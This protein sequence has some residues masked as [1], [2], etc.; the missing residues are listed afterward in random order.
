MFRR[1][2]SDGLERVQVE[3]F[4]NSSQQNKPQKASAVAEG[5]L[6]ASDL[7]YTSVTATTTET[8]VESPSLGSRGNRLKKVQKKSKQA[9]KNEASKQLYEPEGQHAET[10]GRDGVGH[11]NDAAEDVPLP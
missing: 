6:V 10:V 2:K 3:M 5:G 8:T 1:I 11:A 4:S 9:E 7:D